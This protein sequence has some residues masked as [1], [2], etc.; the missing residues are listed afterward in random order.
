MI[1]KKDQ[2][3][4]AKVM[5]DGFIVTMVGKGHT[6]IPGEESEG[7]EFTEYLTKRPFVEEFGL[8]TV[9]THTFTGEEIA[10]IMGKI[11]TER[12]NMTNLVFNTIIGVGD[13][14]HQR[15]LGD[16]LEGLVIVVDGGRVKYKFP[17][18]T[19]RTFFIREFLKKFGTLYH[20]HVLEEFEKYMDKW[21]VKDERFEETYRWGLRIIQQY[22]MNHTRYVEMYG[23]DVPEDAVAEHI[24]VA[25]AVE[26]PVDKTIT[27]DE[28]VEAV[29]AAM[30]ET[31]VVHGVIVAGPVGIGKSGMGDDLGTHKNFVHID[32]DKLGLGWD[33]VGR[34]GSGERTVYQLPGFESHRGRQSACSFYR[35]RRVF[36]RGKIR[37]QDVIKKVYGATVE[38][39]FH[40]FHPAEDD[41]WTD[42]DRLKKVLEYRGHIEQLAKFRKISGGNFGLFKRIR[43]KY[44]EDS[45]VSFYGYPSWE[46]EWDF[47]EVIKALKNPVM[48]KGKYIQH[49]VL[50]DYSAKAKLGHVTVAFGKEDMTRDFSDLRDTVMGEEV[51]YLAGKKTITVI[52]VKHERFGKS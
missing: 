27:T 29:K 52:V 49:R 45:R 7:A 15:Y 1:S 12:N 46:E 36:S 5:E 44:K 24:F 23:D 39:K 17:Y 43:G 47:P 35:R 3:H 21:V 51:T 8:V 32:G 20:P 33:K 11:D 30:P 4:G 48:G 41:A 28:M 42:L 14:T 26:F 38:I 6:F 18:Y 25:D 13:G 22:S 50:A 2:V 16:V 9:E 10:K 19:A 40:I 31:K 37:I 34:D